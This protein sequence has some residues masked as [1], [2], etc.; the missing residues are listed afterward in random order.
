MDDL[1]KKRILDDNDK[2][3]YIDQEKEDP[4]FTSA[5]KLPSLSNRK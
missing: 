1:K 2:F 4:N 5:D 3:M